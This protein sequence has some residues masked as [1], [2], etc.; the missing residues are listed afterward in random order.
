[1]AQFQ[2]QGYPIC[3][4]WFAGKETSKTSDVKACKS[5]KR[6]QGLT[7]TRKQGGGYIMVWLISLVEICN[8]W[9]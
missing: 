8:H 5:K 4:T 9:I 1:M 2:Q 7:L 3:T 6:K